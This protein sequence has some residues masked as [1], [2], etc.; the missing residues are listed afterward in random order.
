MKSLQPLL[1]GLVLLF[2]YNSTAAAENALRFRGKG[3]SGK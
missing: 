3:S 2:A 1:A